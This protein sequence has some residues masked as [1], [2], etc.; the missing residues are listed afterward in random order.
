MHRRACLDASVAIT[1]VSSLQ[2]RKSRL[3]TAQVPPNST[4]PVGFP[5]LAHACLLLG[6]LPSTQ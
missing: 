3:Q 6:Y 1:W 4:N 5:T 2:A